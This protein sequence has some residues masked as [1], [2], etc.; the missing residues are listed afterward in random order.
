MQ[1][2]DNNSKIGYKSNVFFH[3]SEVEMSDD[4]ALKS[5]R[6]FFEVF[7]KV[8]SGSSCTILQKAMNM[9]QTL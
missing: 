2:G 8:D 4:W 3:D 6:C 7:S 1:N 5:P 9:V